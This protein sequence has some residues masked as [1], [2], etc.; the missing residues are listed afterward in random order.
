[1]PERVF[2][3]VSDLQGPG[4]APV[5]RCAPTPAGLALQLQ[6]SAVFERVLG[7]V[8]A[9]AA[10]AAPATPGPRVLLHCSAL[11]A[12]PCALR[13]SQLRVILVADLLARALHAH[14]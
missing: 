11:R 14:G 5:L 2:H 10:P 1:M 12:A 8:E 7:A 13:L 4:V 3:A 6:R 9:Y